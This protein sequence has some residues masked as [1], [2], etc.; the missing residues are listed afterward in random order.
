MRV[1]EYQKNTQSVA[2]RTLWALGVIAGLFSV[3]VCA[4]M[5]A[6]NLRLKANDPIHTPALQRLVQELKASPQNEALKEQIRELD[7]LARRVFFASQHF[8]QV[9]VWLLLAGVAVTI[10]V[11]KTLSTF[12]RKVPYPD[13]HDP[14]DDLAANA[15][16]ARQSVTNVGLIL[17]G[18]A[19]SLA[20]PWKSTL[21]RPPREL[22]DASPPAAKKLAPTAPMTSRAPAPRPAS[23]IFVAL[24]GAISGDYA[25]V[26]NTSPFEDTATSCGPPNSRQMASSLSPATAHGA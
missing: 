15:L 7:Y 13:S 5:I 22:A 11:F 24:S 20:L 6:N 23:R 21:D 3:V 1:V 10:V 2:Y 25:R 8:N 19:L 18:L 16:W 12:H 4:F 26:T 9:A 14:K 17:I